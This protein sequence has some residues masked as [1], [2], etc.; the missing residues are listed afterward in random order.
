MIKLNIA[1]LEATLIALQ[2]SRLA[3]QD[4]L[5][6]VVDAA[7]RQYRAEVRKHIGLR[8]HSLADLAKM[9]HPYARRHGTIRIHRKKPWQVHRQS[10]KMIQALRGGPV[11]VGN[12]PGYEVTFDYGAA[13]HAAHVIQGTR[14]MLPRDVLWRTAMD[15]GTRMAMMRRIVGTLGKRLRSQLGVRFA[16]TAAR[17][18]LAVR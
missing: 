17:G 7:G 6:Y 9:D 8:D 5:P 11:T 2:N 15:E 14:V 18:S 1:G 13:P 3:V 10:D 4:V 16:P 12:K